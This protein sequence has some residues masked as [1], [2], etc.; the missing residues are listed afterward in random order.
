[1]PV[2]ESTLEAL[3]RVWMLCTIW[4]E[5]MCTLLGGGASM[6]AGMGWLLAG[7]NREEA[8]M[9]MVREPL[10]PAFTSSSR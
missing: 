1:M 7:C 10:W 4:I 5:A 9:V 3:K 8:S 2:S 6:K